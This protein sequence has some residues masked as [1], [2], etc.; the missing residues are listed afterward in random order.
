LRSL[1]RNR[2]DEVEFLP[3]MFAEEERGDASF[4]SLLM[5][6]VGYDAFTQALTNPLLSPQLFCEETFSDIGWEA[7]HETRTIDDVFRRNTRARADQR[8]SLGL[9]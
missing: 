6:M 3:G 9:S 5:R 7:I 2:I 1:Y 8:A 4:G